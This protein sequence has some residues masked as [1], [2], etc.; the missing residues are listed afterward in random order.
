MNDLREKIKTRYLQY[1]YG[2]YW[3][4]PVWFAEGDRFVDDILAFPSGLIRK[5]KCP[6]DLLTGYGRP[7]EGCEICH[8]SGT[9]SRP[10][11]ISE[12]LE[13]ADK[14]IEVWW[15]KGYRLRKGDLSALDEI[16]DGIE[17]KK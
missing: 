8:G 5:E 13:I 9:I 6:H 3:D 11:S 7:V 16:L 15:K 4:N 2:K 10:L 12:K 1:R 14:V 17:M